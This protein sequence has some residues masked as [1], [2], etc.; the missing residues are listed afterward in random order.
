MRI[1][2]IFGKTSV[3]GD[4]GLF[5]DELLADDVVQCWG[6]GRRWGMFFGHLATPYLRGHGNGFSNECQAGATS[7]SSCSSF[8]VDLHVQQLLER[9]SED[10]FDR[11]GSGVEIINGVAQMHVNQLGFVHRQF[12]TD[13][14][15]GLQ[16]LKPTILIELH[17]HG[18]AQCIQLLLGDLAAGQLFGDPC[19]IFLDHCRNPVDTGVQGH[20]C[21]PC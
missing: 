21:S 4:L 9:L 20:W 7:G 13:A 6:H 18:L 19:F 3:Q 2:L 15:K 11:D 8:L 5:N 12:A 10:N 16:L 17:V 1:R 14:S